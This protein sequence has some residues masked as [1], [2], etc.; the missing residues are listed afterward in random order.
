MIIIRAEDQQ[1]ED[2]SLWVPEA[3]FV[4]TGQLLYDQINIYELFNTSVLMKWELYWYL[5][6]P[7]EL[8]ISVISLCEVVCL[9]LELTVLQM[10][11]QSGSNS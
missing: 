10:N 6:V 3:V 5:E 7:P 11:I 9:L 1:W 2:T 8:L 4:A